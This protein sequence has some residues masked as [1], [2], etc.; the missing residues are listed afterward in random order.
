[1]VPKMGIR[2]SPDVRF[3]AQF[4]AQSILPAPVAEP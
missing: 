3:P 2:I 1:V 4:N